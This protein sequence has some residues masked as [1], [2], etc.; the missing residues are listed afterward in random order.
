MGGKLEDQ[1]P[2]LF[3]PFWRKY[4][5]ASAGG[6]K[7]TGVFRVPT[8]SKIRSTQKKLELKVLLETVLVKCSI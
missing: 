6:I 4:D 7:K 1:V 5:L 2:L 8:L 3:W